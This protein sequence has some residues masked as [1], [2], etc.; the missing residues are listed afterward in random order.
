MYE[1]VI[2]AEVASAGCS[3]TSHWSKPPDK[4]GNRGCREAEPIGPQN[5][6]SGNMSLKAPGILTFTT[7]VVLVVAVLGVK[8]FG[9]QIPMLNGHEFWALLAA[10]VI[11]VIG[12]M[13]RGL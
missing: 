6:G 5:E 12:C 2:P 13:V 1:R 11:L 4:G 10:H 9:A 8:F 7:S 3:A